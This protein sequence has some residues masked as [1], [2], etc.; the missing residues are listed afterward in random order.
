MRE[1]L[2]LQSASPHLAITA[3]SSLSRGYIRFVPTGIVLHRRPD[4]VPSLA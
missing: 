3:A 1:N 4:T 2:N